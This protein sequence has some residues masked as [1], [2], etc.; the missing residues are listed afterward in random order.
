MRTTPDS[1]RNL[2]RRTM[3]LVLVALA[4]ASLAA[5]ASV[6]PRYSTLEPPVRGKAPPGPTGYK[7][8]APY[9]VGGIWYFPHAQPDYDQTGIASWYGDQFNM[10]PTADGEIF[11]KDVPSAAHTT[12]PLPSLVEVTNLD[13][14][15][16]LVVRVNDRGPF[17]GGRI[18]DLSHAAARELGYDKAGLARVRVRYIGPAPLYNEDTRR[19]ARY[20]PPSNPAVPARSATAGAGQAGAPPA[21]DV[22]LTSR[23]LPRPER[24][25][26]VADLAP[27]A[28]PP[29]RSSAGLRVQA[30]AFSSPHNAE[31]AAAML[32]G[33]GP[34]SIEPITRGGSTLWRV[35]LAAADEDQAEALRLK[36]AQAG[37]PDARV[38]PPF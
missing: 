32:A 19:Y 10:R 12:L 16:K 35:T 17:V 4:G 21:S 14:G 37:F 29:A 25:V 33:A 22:I 24:P 2:S 18:I 30:G 1:A 8:G 15:R 36:A 26:E 9:Q 38:L 3:R 7:T 23:P 6:T 31:R 13:N 20:Q 28:P 34:A 27:P 5:C 11:D